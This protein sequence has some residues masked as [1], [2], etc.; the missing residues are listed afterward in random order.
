VTA[1]H[2]VRIV[3]ALVA[4]VPLGCADAGTRPGSVA[5]HVVTGGEANGGNLPASATLVVARGA[6]TLVVRRAELV[7]R[8]TVLQRARYQE[9]EEEAGEDCAV[10]SAGATRFDLPLGPGAAAIARVPVPVDTY[11]TVQFEI[12][13]PSPDRDSALLASH[14][15][16]AGASLHVQGTF[17]RG[18]ARRD[19]VYRSD[20][21]EVQE[22]V[23]SGPLAV[24]PRG[25]AD[26]TLRVDLAGWFL[27]A[28]GT[29]LL[30][31]SNAVPGTD[32]DLQIRDNVRRSLHASPTAPLRGS[33]S[34]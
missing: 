34:P 28:E 25:S 29:A 11:S 20:F 33:P 22:V 17:S 12:Y 2:G 31:P 14:P 26:V 27:T 24:A 32:D 16:L 6:D 9:C 19:F 5:L 3:V 18:G 4:C 1:L 10:L 23:L 13:R 21:N 30:D 7:L 8:E 15:H